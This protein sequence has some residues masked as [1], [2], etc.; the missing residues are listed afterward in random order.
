M[1]EKFWRWAL[2]LPWVGMAFC[3]LWA[4]EVN[5]HIGQV[6][7]QNYIINGERAQGCLYMYTVG[8]ASCPIFTP[9]GKI[10]EMAEIGQPQSAARLESQLHILLTLVVIFTVAG[11]STFIVWNGQRM[12]KTPTL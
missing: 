2:I 7:A 12:L 6:E 9:Q 5:H 3:G 1:T 4:I 10:N 11:L 8:G